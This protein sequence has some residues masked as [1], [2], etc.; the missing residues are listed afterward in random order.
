[1][2]DFILNILNGKVSKKSVVDQLYVRPKHDDHGENPTIP[3]MN[4]NY[5]HY[6]DLLY[7]PNDQGYLYALVI[8]DQGSRYVGAIELIDR[9]VSDIVKGIKLIYKQSKHLKAPT[10]IISDAGKEFLGNFDQ[11]IQKLGIDYHK[12]VKAGRHRSILAERKNQTIG[13]IISKILT[14]V[15]IASGKPS[16]KWVEFL[17]RIVDI[18]NDKIEEQNLKPPPIETI[19]PVTFNPKTPTNLLMVGDKV[20]VALDNPIDVAGNSLTGRFRTGDIRWN[21]KIRTIKYF[22]MKPNQPIMYFLDGK[23][24]N[25][26]IEAVGYTRNQLQKV[27]RY[28]KKPQNIQ[29]LFENENNRHEVQKITQRGVNDDGVT[30]YL[31]KFKGIRQASWVERETL[32][33]DLGIA[34]MN[35]VDKQLT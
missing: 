22:Y 18:I 19:P 23:D 8:V 6:I 26:E 30:M 27:S 33:Q 25:L 14:Q 11:E 7:L 9:K 13:K 1:M 16:S 32:V 17:P 35:R 34:Y 12:V 24:G 3:L 29:P 4:H 31:V 5:A 2:D 28:E 21:P 20:R 10:V 15:Q